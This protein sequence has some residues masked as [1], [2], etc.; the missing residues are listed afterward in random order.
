MKKIHF[1]QVLLETFQL[2]ALLFDTSV[3]HGQPHLNV[4]HFL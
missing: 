3:S 2:V 1:F 4:K